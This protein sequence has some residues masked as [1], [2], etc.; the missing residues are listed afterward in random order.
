MDA[1][2][3]FEGGVEMDT[4]R[5]HFVWSG[6]PRCSCNYYWYSGVRIE[7]MVQQ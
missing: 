1:G 5:G 2:V 6:S 4:G 3:A 7:A